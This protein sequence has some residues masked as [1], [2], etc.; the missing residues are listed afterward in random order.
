MRGEIKLHIRLYHRRILLRNI[1]LARVICGISASFT[2]IVPYF[3][4]PFQSFKQSFILRRIT[5]Q[6]PS[7]FFLY[8]EFIKS[9]IRGK[10]VNTDQS[11]IEI[12]DLSI[13]FSPHL[14]SL[15]QFNHMI[16]LHRNYNK[17]S[18]QTLSNI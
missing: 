13:D 17:Y 5:S 14:F 4:F 9:A 3:A 10:W 2:L 6:N 18:K 7:I 12:Q 16:Y 1:R 8:N 11:F 15:H